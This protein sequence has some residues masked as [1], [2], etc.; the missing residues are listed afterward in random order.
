MAGAAAFACA[1][2]VIA[3]LIP[4]GSTGLACGPCLEVGG[5]VRAG[6]T[7]G[8]GLR[9][10]GGAGEGEGEGGGG[11]RAAPEPAVAPHRD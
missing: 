10:A 11:P 2:T 9:T 6:M 8:G 3:A 7:D 5:G 4:D 1:S